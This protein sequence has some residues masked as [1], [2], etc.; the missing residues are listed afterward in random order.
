[1]ESKLK[2]FSLGIVVETKPPKTD[3]I[4]VCPIEVLNI[5][6]SGYIKDQNTKFEGNIKNIDNKNFKT[7]INSKN[8]LKAK[9]LAFGHSNRLSAPD[10]V[11]NETVILFKFDNVDEYFWT[12]IFTEPELRRLETVLYGFSNIKGGMV[13]FDKSTSY[14]LEVDTKNK[15]VHFHT[16]M[17]DGEYT[18]YDIIINTKKGTL[19]ITDKKKNYILLD[20]PSDHA[21]VKTNKKISLESG[22]SVN[23]TTPTLNIKANVNISGKV[24]TDSTVD[25]AD[26]TTIG[27]KVIT[28]SDIVSGGGVTS[29]GNMGAGGNI[30]ATGTV[31]D[32]NGVMDNHKH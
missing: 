12:T 3:I 26:T 11:A 7:E 5:L 25:I 32:A 13:G 31:A 18:E 22:V 24:V 2:L 29:K 4:I 6:P 9:W 28:G 27:G 8:Y 1:M 20:S 10:V 21:T 15:S 16:A 30:V 19:S 23:I 17:N 14:W